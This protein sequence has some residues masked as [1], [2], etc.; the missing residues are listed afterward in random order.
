M[1]SLLADLDLDAFLF[2]VEY[3]PRGWEVQ[4]E[5]AVEDGWQNERILLGERLPGSRPEDVP[6]RDQ[7]LAL[8]KRRLV[9]CKRH[10]GRSQRLVR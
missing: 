1:E 5:C 7:V 8:L 9:Q 6:L 4:V 2:A 3:T 10:S